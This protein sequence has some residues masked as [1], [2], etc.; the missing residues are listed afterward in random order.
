MKIKCFLIVNSRGTLR[1]TK[2]MPALNAD[3]IS[4]GINL[5]IPDAIFCRPAW[6]RR[7]SLI[8]T[9]LCHQ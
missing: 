6:K 3:E 8:E 1:V 7:L 5:E 9:Q 2:K 4:V